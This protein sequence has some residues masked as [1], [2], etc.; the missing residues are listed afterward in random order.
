MSRSWQTVSVCVVWVCVCG[1]GGGGV[2]TCVGSGGGT[3]VKCLY[4]SEVFPAP[5]YQHCNDNIF[6][7]QCEVC[8][9]TVSEASAHATV[10]QVC[11]VAANCVRVQ[12]PVS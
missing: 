10:V 12:E 7:L 6:T 2:K 3:T 4:C 1:G 9:V 5:V 11:V 8:S